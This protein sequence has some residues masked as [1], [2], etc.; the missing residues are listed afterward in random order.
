MEMLINDVKVDE[1]TEILYVKNPKRTNG[2][3]WF[4]Y[5]M[6]QDANTIG[7]YLETAEKKYAKADLKY[8]HAKGFLTIIEE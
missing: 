2:K 8:D 3:A 7:E 6:Y 4:R 1:N 5:E